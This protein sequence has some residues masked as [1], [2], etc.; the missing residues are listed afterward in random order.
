MV[1]SAGMKAAIGSVRVSL[2]QAGITRA[3]EEFAAHGEHEPQPDAPLV[4]VACSGG[5]DSMALSVVSRIVCGSLGV[6][7]GAVIIDHGLQKG[8]AAV[9]RQA[10]ER[11][12]KLGLDPVRVVALE[13][14]TGIRQEF[15]TEAAA[16]DVR[17][18]ALTTTAG[19][20]AAQ[21]V[22]LAHTRND[23][24]ESVLLGLLRS[25]GL[26]ALCG[27]PESFVF[28][29]G[30]HNVRFLRPLLGVDR[31]TTTAICQDLELQW[32]DDPGNADDVEAGTT[33]SRDYPLR[34]RVRHD[35][36]PY[37][38]EFTG[39]DVVTAL[40]RTASLARRDRDFLDEFARDVVRQAVTVT[41]DDAL[42]DTLALAQQ[43]PAIRFRVISSA[44][45]ALD[46]P[47]TSSQIEAIDQLI[48]DWH[49]QGQ[50]MLPGHSYAY[51]QRHVIHLCQDGSH[52]NS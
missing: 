45:S 28:S 40:V 2:E 31:A 35:L 13:V 52:A 47:A 21:V 22:L 12:R 29:T 49:G 51:R 20:L 17:Y 16:R 44:L 38:R 11:C 41:N 9:A 4:L 5:R 1:Y 42:I 30:E 46:I 19:E 18:Q 14:P 27:M 43:H 15:G 6:R 10:A 37:L 3:S 50:V 48:V 32:W 24:A 25:R 34:S 39:G 33:L 23:Q 36:I 7:C 8:S 26:D